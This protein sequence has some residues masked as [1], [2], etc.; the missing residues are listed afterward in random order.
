MSSLDLITRWPVRRAAAAVVAPDGA[1]TTVGDIDEVFQL[2]SITKLAT[3]L[4]VLVAVEEGSVGLDQIVTEAGATVAD[5][6]CHASGLAADVHAQ[7]ATP[8]AQR[9]Y[10]TAGYERLGETVASHTEMRF[11]DYLREAVFAPLGMRSSELHG[12]PGANATSTVRD[13]IAL[14]EAWRHAIVVHHSTLQSATA[15]VLPAL[16]GVLPG[17]G[18]FAPNSWGLGPE[19]RG[20]KQPHWTGRSNSPATYGHFGRAGTMLWIDPA[21]GYILIALTD[22]PFGHWA[23]THW[24]AVSDAVLDSA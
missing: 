16:G 4:A 14:A 17:F 3:A 22:E 2:A 20:D 10:S 13:Q 12:S 23:T 11:P 19:I 24:P 6:L 5:L 9:I 15:P 21:A 1:V 8:R 7:L 18:R